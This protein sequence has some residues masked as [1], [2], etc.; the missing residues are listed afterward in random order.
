MAE[1]VT[2]ERKSLLSSQDSE[3]E[4]K[5]PK[6]GFDLFSKMRQIEESPNQ[7][8]FKNTALTELNQYTT[9]SQ[10]PTHDVRNPLIYWRDNSKQYPILSNVS[11]RIFAIQASTGESERHFSCAGE[12][13]TERRSRLSPDCIEAQVLLKEAF[14]NKQW[15]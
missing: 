8:T 4:A 7:I 2:R 15:P 6:L 13:V 5:I 12:V 14:L 3:P 9:E 1:E 11:Q 10:S